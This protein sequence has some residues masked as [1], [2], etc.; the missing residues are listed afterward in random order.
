[1]DAS[2][3]DASWPAGAEVIAIA[4]VILIVAIAQL[5]GKESGLGLIISGVVAAG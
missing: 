1:M 2:S 5:N 4:V 3:G